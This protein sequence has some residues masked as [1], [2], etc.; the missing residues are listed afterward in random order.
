MKREICHINSDDNLCPLFVI[1]L[2]IRAAHTRPVN[3]RCTG[4]SAIGATPGSTFFAGDVMERFSFLTTTDGARLAYRLDGSDDNPTIVLSNSIGTTLR[5]WDGQIAALTQHFRVL[6]YDAR[7]HGA[8]SVPAGPYPLARLGQDVL[9]LM[10]ALDLVR[11][12]FLGLSLGG[13]VGQ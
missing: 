12:H 6:R 8:S 10:D 7:G 2:E 9:E 4:R 13:I 5:M 11:A 3:W 1:L